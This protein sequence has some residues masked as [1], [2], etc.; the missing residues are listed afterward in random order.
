MAR[1]LTPVEIADKQISRVQ[2]SEAAFRS[3]VERVSISPTELAAANLDKARQN[4]AL[5]ITSGKMGDRLKAVSLSSWK[6]STLAKA[7]RLISGITAAKGKIV[8]FQ[9]Q[10][11]S[12][13]DTID[14][15]LAAM[16]TKTLTENIARATYQM[17]Q[18]SEF[19]F[20][21]GQS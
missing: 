1:G 11:Q 10:R 6:N 5:S 17:R 12:W 3:G 7:D 13:Q 20:K 21:P 8:D 4:Y 2:D 14:R 15:G 9:E 18:M 16:P 19:T